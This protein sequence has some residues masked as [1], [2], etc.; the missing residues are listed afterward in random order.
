MKSD[1]PSSH[2]PQDIL[3]TPN[4]VLAHEGP[5]FRCIVPIRKAGPITFPRPQHPAPSHVGPPSHLDR[6]LWLYIYWH[7]FTAISF[8]LHS[9]YSR[10]IF[11]HRFSTLF[12]C[13]TSLIRYVERFLLIICVVLRYSNV[14]PPQG[15]LGK[16]T[17]DRVVSA[18]VPSKLFLLT[19]FNG[20][21][22]LGPP[23]PHPLIEVLV[24]ES[25]RRVVGGGG[26]FKRRENRGA[27]WGLLDWHRTLQSWGEGLFIWAR[28]QGPSGGGGGS[29]IVGGIYRPAFL[30]TYGPLDNEPITLSHQ[31]CHPLLHQPERSPLSADSITSADANSPPVSFCIG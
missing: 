24:R 8:W 30:Q 26:W 2:L 6:S 21:M 7:I 22:V 15:R 3:L 20:S 11:P 4:I 17:D 18:V 16:G 31:P 28:F 14:S 23:P 12:F 5:I 29:R 9:F 27:A 1:A 19:V 13:N 25:A 10:H